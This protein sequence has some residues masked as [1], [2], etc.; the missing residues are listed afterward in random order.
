MEKIKVLA[1]ILLRSLAFMIIWP[2]LDAV[3]TNRAYLTYVKEIVDAFAGEMSKEYALRYTGIGGS[4]PKNVQEISVNF[5]AHRKVMID[6]ARKMEVNGVQNLL[7]KINSH[8]K[9][10][11]FLAV[12]PFTPERVCISVAFYNED[13]EYYFDGSVA[14]VSFLNGKIYYNSAELRKGLTMPFSD[15]RDPNNIIVF[16]Q[17]EVIEEVLVPILDE[18]F[19]AAEKIVKGSSKSI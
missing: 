13:E 9:L 19:E 18:S 17:K 8:E 1:R 11:E 4:M 10:R 6:E 16:P 12:Y 15:C 3:E 7:N 2:N 14:Y 5:V